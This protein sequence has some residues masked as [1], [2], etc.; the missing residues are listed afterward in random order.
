MAFRRLLPG[1]KA[2]WWRWWIVSS[3]CSPPSTINSC[4]SL[5]PAVRNC[6]TSSWVLLVPEIRGRDP[7]LADYFFESSHSLP[8]AKR[9]EEDRPVLSAVTICVRSRASLSRTHQ[10]H[11]DRFNEFK[12]ANMPKSFTFKPNWFSTERAHLCFGSVLKQ[13]FSR[14]GIQNIN[15]KNQY[16]FSSLFLS[17]SF[18]SFILLF[19]GVL[20]N[21]FAKIIYLSRRESSLIN[22]LAQKAKIVRKMR[23]PFKNKLKM[24]NF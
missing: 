9:S 4:F 13:T 23:F 21:L 8:I 11:L 24:T 10:K 5:V 19:R 16:F 3:F 7:L 14:V 2:A 20:K 15:L 17:L 22:W 6:C 12:Q 1:K 18:R